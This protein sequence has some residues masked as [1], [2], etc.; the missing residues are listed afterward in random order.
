M[1]LLYIYLLGVFI[2]SIF[3]GILVGVKTTSIS[4]ANSISKKKEIDKGFPTDKEL[5]F[6]I[7]FSWV[8]IV[9]FFIALL[10]MLSIYL[11]SKKEK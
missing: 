7:L 3:A 4:K 8:S 6:F 9:V 1:F 5:L 11:F 2:T 10:T